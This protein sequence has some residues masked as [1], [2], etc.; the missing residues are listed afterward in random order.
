MRREVHLEVKGAIASIIH[1]VKNVATKHIVDGLEKN[2]V[3]KLGLMSLICAS[4]FRARWLNEASQ[5]S[6][7]SKG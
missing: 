3:M 2:V 5:W 4:A 1:C 6:R 7:V